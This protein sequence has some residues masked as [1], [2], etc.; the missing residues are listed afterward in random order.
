MK[1]W[2]KT[3]VKPS[4]PIIEVI[5]I[6]D[7][8]ALQIALVVNE[9]RRLLGTVTDG[10]IR[11][12]ILRGIS[13]EDKLEKIMCKTPI[14]ASEDDD[15]KTIMEIMKLKDI[16]QIP[17]VDDSGRVVGLEILKE[18]VHT[19]K[20][21]N[22]VVIMAGGMGERLR[23]LTD[24]CPKPLIKVGVKP[25][26][27]IILEEFINFGFRRFFLSVN[28]KAEMIENHF[29]D[30]SKWGVKILY[31]REKRKMGTAG[32]LSL[33]PEMPDTPFFVMNGDLLTKVNFRH[34]LDFHQEHGAK[35]TMC[36]REYDFQV[37]YGVVSAEKHR[38]LG[39][40]EKP[41]HKF[42]V[43]AGIY[44]LNPDV[45]NHIPKDTFYDMTSVFENLIKED[46]D[47]AV[48]PIREYWIDIGRKAD[49]VR[50]NGEYPEQFSALD[51]DL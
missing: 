22:I 51:E 26:L 9:D 33:L 10:D 20:R 5:K 32:S 37:P 47:V 36:V 27:E 28:Y 35:A 15:P 48:F 39:V 43:N 6:I 38:L 50:A 31:L 4:D 41:I 23:P 8:G 44:V 14:V 17:V 45:I 3:L 1:D 7:S 34:L 13:L 46:E 18:L 49:F 30:G 25:I 11:S 21:D 19:P 29:G 24:D 2:K 40:D 12:G 42:F 16:L